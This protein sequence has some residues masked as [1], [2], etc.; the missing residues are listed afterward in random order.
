MATTSTSGGG[1]RR[2]RRARPF[3]GGLLLLIA[4]LE[5]F[6]SANLSLGDLQLH[7][8]PE[9]Y[10]SYLLPLM[11][12]LCGVLSWVTPGQRLFYGILG[13]LTAVYS[14]IGLNLGGFFAGMLLGIVG[15]A[16]VL[17][18]SPRQP[19]PGTT[20]TAPEDPE[21]PHGEPE[22]EGTRE[23]ERHDARDPAPAGT[24]LPGFGDGPG[25]GRHRS[26][27][28][29]RAEWY[30]AGAPEPRTPSG[31][32]PRKMLAIALVPL[33]V[34]AAVLAAA[35]PAP[36]RAEPECPE[37]L[38]SRPA[39]AAK[40]APSR[41]PSPKP[42]RKKIPGKPAPAKPGTGAPASSSPSP[43]PTEDGEDSGNP[44]VDGLHDFV[45]GVGDLFGIGGEEEEPTPGPSATPSPTASPGP[46][47]SAAPTAAPSGDPAGSGSPAPGTSPTPSTTPSLPDVPC[48][49]PRVVKEAGPDDVPTVSLRGGKLET[50]SLTMYDST[51]DGV[52]RLQTTGGTIQALKFSMRK[53]VN[54]P[55]KLTVP[56]RGTARTVIDSKE[57]ITEGDVR[58]YTPRFKGKLFGVIPVTFTPE[59]PPPLTL[60][61][62]WFTDVE[63]DLAFVRCDTLTGVPL[64]LTERS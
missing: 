44:L 12:V 60:P 49:G 56:E 14:L 43:T 22:P 8:G 1:F 33:A 61:V 23:D 53:A 37:G 35:A 5:L 50:A 46:T 36:A 3:W 29:P 17:A 20:D 47:G 2:W 39:A 27:F 13:L 42:S 18:W 6:L 62:L 26:A 64:T 25:D 51:Y 32:V 58:F 24:I 54:K 59:S 15:G 19:R 9:G 55:F 31:G 57:L 4:G 21:G 45:E 30:P 52:T 34:T 48:L 10:L 16:L 38:P 63:I 28:R 7:F 40:K 41:Q 11:L